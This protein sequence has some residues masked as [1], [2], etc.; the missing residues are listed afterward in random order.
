MTDPDTRTALDFLEH[1]AP[2]GPWVLSA[3]EPDGPIQTRTFRDRRT[4]Q[5]WIDG[6]QGKRNIYFSVNVPKSDLTKK[7]TKADIGELRA[8]HCDLDAPDDMAP[9][10]AK[11][12][13]LLPRLKAHPLP[14][15]IIIDSGGGLQSYWLLCDPIPLNG[16]DS[17]E[18]LEAYNRQLEIDLGGDH[19]HNIDRI[20][21]LPGTINLPNAKK[22]AKGRGQYLATVIEAHWERRYT[23]DQFDSAAT[24]SSKAEGGKAP[25]TRKS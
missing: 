10:Q 4:A 17:I 23:L 21:R 9:E 24:P 13:L 16:P 3:I 25:R 19:C 12:E 1:W 5:K 18:R 2:G 22:R 11:A 20:M 7:A 15:S 6:W 8:F 14:P